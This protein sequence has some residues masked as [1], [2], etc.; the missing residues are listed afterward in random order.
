MHEDNQKSS[1]FNLARLK[2][3]GGFKIGNLLAVDPELYQKFMKYLSKT[4]KRDVV[5]KNM[6]FLTGLSAFSKNPI[7]LF[8]K[9]ESSIGKTYNVIEVLKCF[10]KEDVWLL[11]G[12]SPTALVHDRGKLID[13][14]GEEIDLG[15]KPVKPHKTDY[16]SESDYKQARQDYK[17]EKETW[18]KRL[19]NSRYLVDLS[20]KILCFLEAPYIETFNRLRPILSHDTFQISYKFTDKTARGKLQTQH[21]VIQ[22]FPACIFCSTSQKYLK[23]LA[24]RSFTVTPE[25]TEEKYHDANVL[26]GT[27]AAFPWKFRRDFD[28]DLL[29]GYVRFLR[30]NLS[31]FQVVVPYAEV[32]A[33]KFPSRFPRSM[34]DFKHVLEL[35]KVS[36]LFYVSQRPVLVQKVEDKEQCYVMAVREDYEFVMALWHEIRETTETSASGQI[37][38]FFH[39]VVEEVAESLIV[40][41]VKDLVDAWNSKFKQ[42]KSSRRIREWINFLCDVGYLTKNP[43]PKDKRSNLLTVIKEKNGE[44]VESQFGVIFTLDLFKAWLKQVKEILRKNSLK[45]KQNFVANGEA[46]CEDIYEKFYLNKPNNFRRIALNGS[47]ASFVESGEEK[48]PIQQTPQSPHFKS[49]KLDEVLKI[50][51]LDKGVD[52]QDKC[53]ECGFEGAMDYQVT[54]HDGK[55]GF[56]CGTC[57]VSLIQQKQEGE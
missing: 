12:L 19:K 3:L 55:W 40:F 17:E 50:E 32:F 25:I 37:M 5:T 51:R 31:D 21:V 26:T 6:V 2:E 24:T 13:D 30:N 18:I 53:V 28:L 7:N 49:F 27:K 11:G 36:A 23:D 9:G 47:K 57:G 52:F 39:E 38:K 29:E 10:P 44:Y 45:F 14:N 56:L 8:L 48:T 35:V 46:S 16:Q 43:N 22:G 4:V 20:G 54:F 42:K 41:Q 15:N 1:L 33:E 34:R